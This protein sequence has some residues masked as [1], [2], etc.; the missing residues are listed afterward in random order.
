MTYI[1]CYEAKTIPEE[2]CRPATV[3]NYSDLFYRVTLYRFRTR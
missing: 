3:N 2:A 1:T